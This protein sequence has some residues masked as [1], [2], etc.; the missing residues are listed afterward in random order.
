MI[1][2][3]SVCYLALFVPN[4]PLTKLTGITYIAVNKCKHSSFNLW[5]CNWKPASTL[6]NLFLIRNSFLFSGLCNLWAKFPALCWSTTVAFIFHTFTPSNSLIFLKLCLSQIFLACQ[7]ISLIIAIKRI[8]VETDPQKWN[9]KALYINLN[10]SGPFRYLFWNFHL[11]FHVISILFALQKPFRKS[12][13]LITSIFPASSSWLAQEEKGHA[14]LA[15]LQTF[16]PLSVMFSLLLI[17]FSKPVMC[18]CHLSVDTWK[19][20]SLI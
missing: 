18:T 17:T 6:I 19:V 4:F 8:W 15:T 1:L 5:H 9:A 12:F 2:K 10:V 11:M 7:R 20:G 14:L 16:L 13:F 3:I